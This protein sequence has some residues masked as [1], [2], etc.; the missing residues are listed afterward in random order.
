MIWWGLTK[1]NNFILFIK[2]VETIQVAPK[3]LDKRSGEEIVQTT[4]SEQIMLKMVH[5]KVKVVRKTI[6]RS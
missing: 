4:T 3:P 5:V 2:G 6:G 1:L